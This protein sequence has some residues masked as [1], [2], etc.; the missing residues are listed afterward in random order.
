MFLWFGLLGLKLKLFFRS[1]TLNQTNKR[2]RNQEQIQ[3]LNYDLLW[4][5]LRTEETNLILTL[6]ID[7]KFKI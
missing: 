6:K 2:L 7:Q 5:G 1:K 4:L 3:K